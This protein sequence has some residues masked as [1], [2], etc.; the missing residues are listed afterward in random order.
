MPPSSPSDDTA[1]VPFFS[2]FS[3]TLRDRYECSGS[4]KFIIY[5]YLFIWCKAYFRMM[6]I[7]FGIIKLLWLDEYART[8]NRYDLAF[9]FVAPRRFGE[10]LHEPFLWWSQLQ[11]GRLDSNCTAEKRQKKHIVYQK[12]RWVVQFILKWVSTSS[13]L[14]GNELIFISVWFRRY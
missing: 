8:T 14:L 10:S 3:S 5:F 7:A 1:A 11:K 2:R 9:P 12:V 13:L 4:Y 6:T